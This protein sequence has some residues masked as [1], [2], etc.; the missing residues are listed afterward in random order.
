M[1]KPIRKGLKLIQ[2]LGIDNLV[3]NI[4]KTKV[5]KNFI[6][7]NFWDTTT[8]QT[9][10]KQYKAFDELLSEYKIQ[11]N[12]KT[13]LEIGS[14]NSIG[15]GYYFYKDGYKLWVASDNYRNPQKNK[16][17]SKKEMEIA[18]DA[19][20]RFGNE[21][22]KDISIENDT[23]QYN[24]KLDFINLDI[25]K[26]EQKLMNK[27]DLIFSNAV[28]EHIE[29]KSMLDSFK[30]MAL[31]L[32]NGGY[33]IHRVDLRD[34]INVA[35][36][37]N[38][39]KYSTPEWEKTTKGSIFYTNRLRVSDYLKII[40]KNKLILIDMV[41]KETGLPKKI[42]PSLTDKYDKNDLSKYSLTLI[43]KKA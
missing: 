16:K 8:P 34:H 40:K 43:I 7:K 22:L 4:S 31:Y 35:N 28:L 41:T 13:I 27:F 14:G 42:H 37:F 19:V 38:F 26:Q 11:I 17:L 23:I 39:Y 24:G 10:F 3:V 25:G 12:N 29:R 30:N 33:M 9:Y 15:M 32:K 5:F 6:L 20:S 2:Q 21:L 1:N 36:P 18:Q